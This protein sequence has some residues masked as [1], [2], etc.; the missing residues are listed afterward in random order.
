V[1]SL[2]HVLYF[3]LMCAFFLWMNEITLRRAKF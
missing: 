3:F 2:G 1:I